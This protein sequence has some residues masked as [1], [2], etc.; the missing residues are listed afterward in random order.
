MWW[1]IPGAHSWLFL[2]TVAFSTITK[3]ALHMSNPFD[4]F[5]QHY[6]WLVSFTS[7]PLPLPA[8]K[9]MDGW[10]DKATFVN[11]TLKNLRD[12]K[13]KNKEGLPIVTYTYTVYQCFQHVVVCE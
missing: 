4:F 3:V 7:Q 2:L 8:K 12:F 10:T 11:V 5:T 13:P 1:Y 6:M 9:G